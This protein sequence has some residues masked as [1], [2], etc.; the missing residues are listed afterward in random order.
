MT[1]MSKTPT[2]ETP[3]ARGCIGCGQVRPLI[4]GL[5]CETCHPRWTARKG[6]LDRLDRL[7]ASLLGA[8]ANQIGAFHEAANHDDASESGMSNA[9]QAFQRL[10][11]FGLSSTDLVTVALL[12]IADRLESIHHALAGEDSTGGLL[13]AIADST[14][15]LADG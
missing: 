12:L 13:A 8:A 7:G 3:P 10:T 6:V 9:L 11:G 15:R 2:P 4:D 5:Y 1:D 14:E